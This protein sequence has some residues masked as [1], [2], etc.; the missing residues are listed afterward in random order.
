MVIHM[1][2]PANRAPSQE[3]RPYLVIPS[4]C[5]RPYLHAPDKM[6]STTQEVPTKFCQVIGCDVIQAHNEQRLIDHAETCSVTTFPREGGAQPRPYF[7]VLSC[8]HTNRIPSDLGCWEF[9]R[10]R[11]NRL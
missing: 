8:K 7:P 1:S 2:T 9:I 5:T 3:A 6:I 11:S 10:V 4:V